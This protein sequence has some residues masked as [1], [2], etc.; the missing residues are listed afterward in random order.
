[1]RRTKVCLTNLC[2]ALLI[3]MMGLA[4]G[5]ATNTALSPDV[6]Y[7]VPSCNEMECK[8]SPSLGEFVCKYNQPTHCHIVF[9]T[10]FTSLNAC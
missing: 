1:M 9:E 2:L 6:A 5:V 7:A 8:L 3:G 10:C 4:G